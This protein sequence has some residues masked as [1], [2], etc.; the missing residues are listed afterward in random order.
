[1]PKDRIIPQM[2]DVRPVDETGDL[3]W[4][5]IKS[6]ESILKLR[7]KKLENKEKII[8]SEPIEKQ[9]LKPRTTRVLP[10]NYYG[11]HFK[12]SKIYQLGE[13][14]KSDEIPIFNPVCQDFE[15]KYNFQINPSQLSIKDR[16]EPQPHARKV[17]GPKKEFKHFE[18]IRT[19]ETPE[20]KRLSERKIIATK[21]TTPAQKTYP[22]QNPVSKTVFKEKGVQEIR[23]SKNE[24]NK[25]KNQFR[26][27]DLF[28]PAKFTFSFNPG[29]SSLYFGGISLMIVLLI[30]GFSFGMRGLK[31]K[32]EVL[33]TSQEGYSD[34][35]SAIDAIKNQNFE[36]SA[37]AFEDSY[38]KFSE[39]SK[40]LDEMGRVFIEISRF[41]PFSSKIS[42][43][44]NLVEAGKHISVAGQ[45]LNRIIKTVNSL[46]NPL[47][48]NGKNI[49]FLEI[50]Q[51][52]EKEIQTLS[53]EINEIEKNVEKVNV[54]DLPDDK[55]QQF[56]SL[57][58]RIPEVS[59]VVDEFLGNSEIF[60]DLLGGNGPRKYLFL[61]QN[62]QEMRATGGFIGTYGLLDISEGRI[63]NFF[64]DGIFNPDGQL[65]EKIVPPKPIQKISAAWS[66]HDSNW[67]PDFPTSAKEAIIFY[68]KTGGPTADGVIALTP[69]VMQKLLEITGPIEMKEY[70]VTIDSENFIEKTQYQ[71]EVN[72]DKE[73]NKPKKILSDLAPIILDKIFNARDPKS[74]AKTF[75]ALSSGLREKH[76]LLYSENKSLQKIISENHWS[77]EIINTQKDYISVINTN[78]NGFKTDGVIDENV[79]H[80]AEIQNDGSIID[81]VTIARRHNGGDSA[82]EWWN[83]VN[84]DYMRV[85]VPLGS[86]LLEVEGQTREINEDVLDYDALG[87]KRNP[88]I[89]KEEKGMIIDENS[90]TRIYEESGKTVFANWVY[91]SPKETVTIKYKYLLP[92]KIN[93]ISEEKPADS[94][95]LLAQKQSGSIGSRFSFDISLPRDYSVIWNYPEN[96]ERESNKL[97]IETDLKT[98]AF[99][100]LVFTKEGIIND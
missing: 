63:R 94:Y 59:Q 32:G 20:E 51:S 85:Y 43:G 77:G 52:T 57:K 1:M 31:I 48:E 42:S 80:N 81:T 74:I 45:S 76:V 41:V 79:S 84:D 88:L 29:K 68:E 78:I 27:S 14:F 19:F 67:F 66:L 93:F 28:I 18:K 55:Q 17:F 75:Q 36:S 38:N 91:V 90:G 50:F 5:K 11:N 49:S 3:D 9:V 64:I 22:Q 13:K 99:F 82:Y 54:L 7:E 2:F 87:F 58:G 23:Y 46:E 26:F 56:I 70:E 62:N 34:L 60:V 8:R 69:T 73:E 35:N 12:D 97:K 40:S 86:K 61:F 65:Q 89:E 72:Y 92:F 25:I 100:G 96:L 6:I 39:A 95:S 10:K 37:L 24:L 98:D 71:V 16:P 83:M 4:E 33:G 47:N 21:E 15:E 30:C 53:Q 44:K